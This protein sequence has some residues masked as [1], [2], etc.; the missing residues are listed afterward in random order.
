MQQ[1]L[2]RVWCNLNSVL[3]G[4]VLQRRAEC[5]AGWSALE[6]GADALQRAA[7]AAAQ[8][9]TS[10]Q[11]LGCTAVRMLLFA[12]HLEPTGRRMGCGGRC[13]RQTHPQRTH[14]CAP[15]A[16]A[17]PAPRRAA[18]ADAPADAPR[19]P[20]PPGPPR[21]AAPPRGK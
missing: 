4:A 12:H 17:R 11:L 19:P 16:R 3:T 6:C 10:R 13:A 8:P 21:A 7:A 5:V 18:P 9:P 15:H 1:Q 14:V 2:Q 20:P